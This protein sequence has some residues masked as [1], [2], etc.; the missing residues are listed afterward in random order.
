MSLA[1]KENPIRDRARKL[2][3]DRL[4]VPSLLLNLSKDTGWPD[5][6]FLI[7]GG[8]PLLMEFKRPGEPLKPLQQERKDT[9][10]KLSYDVLGPVD[11]VDVALQLVG[12]AVL[13]NQVLRRS[14]MW[15]TYA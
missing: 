13:A 9:L 8:R 6:L 4:G 7:P 5:V 11:S 14:A 2:A 10:K 3:A 1:P 12:E 15:E